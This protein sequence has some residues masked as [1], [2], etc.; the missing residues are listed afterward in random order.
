MR[1]VGVLAGR[2]LRS[3]FSTPIAY[4]LVGGYL[5]FAGF[6]FFLGLDYFLRAIEQIM[7]YQAFQMLERFN[8]TQQVIGP[9][10]GA[11][12]FLLLI[13]I[14]LL[15]MRTFAEERANGTIELLLTSP[16]SSWEIV[17][18]KYLATLVLMVLL[19][20]LSGLYPVL[21][22][23]YGDPGPELAQT[24]AGLGGLLGYSLALAA[25][26]TFIS[27]L[28][29]SQIVA[30]L[31]GMVVGLLLLL[32]DAAGEVGRAE[33]MGRVFEYVGIRPHFE[34]AMQG[35]LRL[36]DLVYFG[37]VITLFLTLSRTRVE[38]FRWP[39]MSV[40][41]E[42][43]LFALLALIVLSFWLVGLFTGAAGW[44]TYLHLGA[45]LGLLGYAV[46]T[47]L[48]QLREQTWGDA[49]RRGAFFRGNALM[50]TALLV[51][52]LTGVAWVSIRYPLKWDLTEAKVHTLSASTTDVL[53]EIGEQPIEVLAFFTSGTEVA[54]REV[55]ERY[56]YESD[57]FSFKIVDP[58]QRPDLS[59]R[60]EVRSNGILLVCAG[61]CQQATGVVR[62][63]E[64]SEQELTRAVRSVIST[65]KKV[66]FVMG[67]GEGAIDD[68]EV[69]GYS[70]IVEA[71]RAENLVV[72]ALLLAGRESVP[73]DADAVILAGATHSVLEREL[74]ALDRYLR[75][76][77]AV[78]VLADPIFVTNLEPKVREW[79]IELGDDLI[80]DQTIEL[81]RGPQLGVEP[82]V[83]DF[84]EHPITEDFH[85]AKTAMVVFRLA[86]SVSAANGD[87]VVE[88]A[89]TGRSSWAESDVEQFTRESKVGLGDT[90][91]PGPIALAA[92]RTF[93]PLEGSENGEGRLV[94]VGDADF[95]RNRYVAQGY[96]ADLFLN[97]VNWLVGEEQ[98]ATIDRKVPRASMAR[99]TREQFATFQYLAVFFLPEA[100]LVAGIV[101]WWRRRS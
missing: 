18:G 54:A 74:D 13:V 68:E 41:G 22:F 6:I 97:M 80:V 33:V 46:Y 51:A 59:E 24:L 55:L 57:R 95:A 63:L 30:G 8:L 69:S 38:S 62:V 21:L 37:V 76:G 40:H 89:H 87:E 34:K 75:A 2:E 49:A 5:V 17:L 42:G 58:K 101:S 28:T 72:E 78:A 26:G 86:R 98:F 100:I 70:R 90:D 12:T 67:H 16:I 66:Y 52:I 77:G 65:Q 39:G 93:P 71:L 29:R 45:G 32:I 27:S 83:T 3:V 14:P 9:A 84:A 43:P 85:R 19:V 50:Q 15:T 31:V 47:L 61:P 35:I 4:V 60:F 25:I 73:E 81:F 99:M 1:H 36:Q 48:P 94:V 7:V 23:I 96:N 44:L 11:F 10:F 82:V 20:G 91:R 88:L 64:P 56:T 79:G 92:A 53:A